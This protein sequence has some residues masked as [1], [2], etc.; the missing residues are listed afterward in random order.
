MFFLHLMLE[1]KGLKER[2]GFSMVPVQFQ[3]Q[4]RLVSNVC[5]RNL[6]RRCAAGSML[7]DESRRSG[8]VGSACILKLGYIK[9]FVTVH[10]SNMCY[11]KEHPSMGSP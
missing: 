6:R 10:Q 3:K 5:L 8:P 2:T 11:T 4:S 7:G 9:G 1:E